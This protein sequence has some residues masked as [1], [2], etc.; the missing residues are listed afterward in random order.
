MGALVIG[1]Y[2]QGPK[3]DF[4]RRFSLSGSGKIASATALKGAKDIGQPRSLQ[5]RPLPIVTR[6]K[7]AGVQYG[8]RFNVARLGAFILS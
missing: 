3:Q 7:L 4:D 6:Q 8:G 5:N 1:S 2:L